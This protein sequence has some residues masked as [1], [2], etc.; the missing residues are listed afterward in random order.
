MDLVAGRIGWSCILDQCEII[1]RQGVADSP[2][3][4]ML[5]CHFLFFL[6]PW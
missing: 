6:A 2:V 4:M 1:S 3:E 5:D